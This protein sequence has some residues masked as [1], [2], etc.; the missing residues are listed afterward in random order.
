[1]DFA[2]EILAAEKDPNRRIM[3]HVILKA[4]AKKFD[5][6]ELICFILKKLSEE[7][8]TGVTGYVLEDMGWTGLQM[9]E[10]LD[11]VFNFIKRKEGYLRR[12]AITLLRYFTI[13]DTE[14]ENMLLDIIS[15]EEEP[16]TVA[17]ANVVLQTKGTKKAIEPLRKVITEHSATNA[18]GTAI[19]A[20]KNI[21]GRNQLNFFIRQMSLKE[22][23]H[24]KKI[25]TQSI[26]EHGDARAVDIMLH[27]V[28][29]ILS[30]PNDSNIAYINGQPELID[31]L[32]FLKKFW[33][34]DTRIPPLF[35]WIAQER[36]DYMDRTE[37]SMFMEIYE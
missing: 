26:V 23:A 21:D 17:E 36:F 10:H 35:K 29:E 34:S 11:I 32:I 8:S 22:D 16:Y 18:L 14:I 13:K 33:D 1:V 37:K 6:P 3:I 27:R 20:L 15:T 2:K 24:V 19:L 28:R 25:L 9:T 31:A 7:E 5:K 12:P 4:F 30:K